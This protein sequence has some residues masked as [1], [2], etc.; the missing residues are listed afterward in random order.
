MKLQGRKLELMHHGDDVAL[1]HAE[2][3]ALDFEIADP[4]DVFGSTTLLAVRRFQ[5]DH[6]L[7]VTGIVDARTA[8]L[9]NQAVDALPRPTWRVQGRLL[10]SDGQAMASARVRAF[11]KRLRR[12][13]VLG[14][15]ATDATGAYGIDYP[16]PTGGDISLY[17]QAFS[18]SGER[19]AGSELACHAKPVETMDLVAGDGV[20]R[21]RPLFARLQATLQ[22]LLTPDRVA[23][24]E[25]SADDVHWL[26]CRHGLDEDQLGRY[27]AAARLAREAEL[28]RE[29][30]ALFGLLMQNL[31]AVLQALLA[32]APRSLRQALERAIAAN[33]ISAALSPRIGTIIE[34][35]Q[36]VIVRLALREPAPERP[37]FAL[38]FDVA[39]TPAQHRE[40]LLTDHLRHAGTLAEFWEAQR[41][42]LGDEATGE[43]QHVLRIAALGL[44]HAPLLRRLMRMRASGEV[45]RG[46]E[47]LARFDRAAWLRLI[48]QRE[49]AAAIGAPSFLG[50]EAEARDNLFATYLARFVEAVA[51]TRVLTERLANDTPPALAA[52]LS[53]L[54]R[55]PRFEFRDTRVGDFLRAN[56]RALEGDPDPAA[57]RATLNAMQRLYDLAPPF[58]K[59]R[60]LR[61]LGQ[62]IDSA[63]QIR[64][65]GE[66]A[67]VRQAS[68]L[69]GGPATARAVYAKAAQKADT[70]VLLLSQSAYMN[71]TPLRA[72]PTQLVGPGMPDLADLFGS[73]DA[74]ECR[75]C[76][77]VYSPAAYLVD[78]LHFLMNCR[79]SSPGRS[80]LA[81][82]FARR[83]DLGEVDLTCDN[84]HTTLPYVDLVVEI[85]ENAVAPGGAFPFQTAGEAADLLASPAHVQSAAYG[86]QDNRL[87]GAV[88]PWS[89]PFD[90]WTEVARS[91]LQHMGVPRVELIQGFRAASDANAAADA[92]AEFLG[93]TA[94][95]RSALLLTTLTARRRFWGFANAAA[96][97]AFVQARNVGALLHRARMTYDELVA[98][99]AVPFVDRASRL[100]VEFAG[101]DCNLDTA[102]IINL[103]APALDRLHRFMR[104]QRKLPW[105]IDELGALLGTLIV[106][107]LDDQ[108]LLRIAGV[109]RLQQALGV[110]LRTLLGWWALRMDTHGI[111]S[112]LSLYDDVFLDPS[113]SQ[114]EA[115]VFRLN[116]ARSE[117]LAANAA[118][119]SASLPQ[120][121]TALGIS[122]A[123][124]D[125]LRADLPNDR[126]NLQNLTRLQASASLAKALRLKVADYLSLRA[127]SGS[128]PTGPAAGPGVTARFVDLAR[129]A[130]LA[131]L[132]LPLLDYL[133]RHRFTA[134]AAFALADDQIAVHLGRLRAALRTSD[135]EFLLAPAGTDPNLP[136]FDAD[137][138]AT[139]TAA[140]LAALLPED[141]VRQALAV[142]ERTSTA[143]PADLAT[144]IQQALGRFLD[145]AE[146][147]E[148][149][150]E[151]GTLTE[152]RERFNYFLG[153]LLIY[154]RRSG[155]EAVAVAHAAEW[156]GI[157]PALA[158]TLLR[159]LV[160][161][162]ADVS[163][164]IVVDLV[165]NH[166]VGAVDGPPLPVLERSA[167]PAP[168]AALERLHKLVQAAKRL[169]LPESVLRF[170]IEEGPSRGWI[171]LAALPLSPAAEASAALG[172]FLSMV[173]ALRA[174]A[175]LPGGWPDFLALLQAQDAAGIGRSGY[176]DAVTLRT[177]WDRPSVEFVSG[178]QGLDLS[179]P[180][181]YRSGAFLSAMQPR[182]AI[183]RRLGVTGGTAQAW[184][185]AAVSMQ[186]AQT[187][188]QTARAKY[189]DKD[190]WLAV[191]R[192]LRDPLRERQRAAL[193]DHLLHRHGL[194]SSNEL[195]GHY[196]VD[197]EMSPCM[198]T[199]RMVLATAS[200]QLFVQRCLLNLE[201]DVPPS[202]IDTGQWDWMKNYR[203]WEANR[204]VFLYPENWIEPE[205]RDDKSPP[206]LALEQGLL[207]DE[208]TS[209]TVEREYLTYLS[210]LDQV[211][212]LEIVAMCVGPFGQQ[213]DAVHVFGRTRNEPHGYFY[214][215]W[216][217][218]SW[219]PWEPMDVGI[220]GNHLVPVFWNGRLTV[221]W[222]VFMEKAL[223]PSAAALDPDAP[224]SPTKY[225]DVSL[226]W[227]ELREESWSAKR[228]SEAAIPSAA[229][230]GSG[231]PTHFLLD[232]ARH[233]SLVSS[234]SQDRSIDIGL[235]VRA[236]D[237][238]IEF[239]VDE[240]FQLS[241]AGGADRATTSMD[242]RKSKLWPKDR[243]FPSTI[244]HGNTILEDGSVGLSVLTTSGATAD[245]AVSLFGRTPGRF[246]V[247][248][249]EGERPFFCRLPFFYL[250]RTRAF[251][252]V[253]DGRYLVDGGGGAHFLDELTAGANPT[254]APAAPLPPRPDLPVRVAA[255]HAAVASTALAASAG[256]L[257][258]IAG[259]AILPGHWETQRFHFQSHHHPFVRLLVEQLSRFGIDGI[260]KPD[261][262]SE[263]ALPGAFGAL[264]RQELARPYFWADYSP[265]RDVVEN[266]A[267][268]PGGLIAVGA[269]RN[270]QP[271]DD[272]DFSFGGAYTIYN[273]ELFFH[274]PF[275]IAKR[276][277]ANRRFSEANRWFTYL[278]DPT[279]AVADQEASP[280]S[281]AERA[282]NTK[283]FVEHGQ[284]RS[285]ERLLLLL[286]QPG[287]D[288]AQRLQRDELNKQLK[289]WRANPFNPHLIARLR[290]QPYMMA[291][292][293]AY[294][295]NLIAWGDD[296]FRRDT[297][298]S[299][300]EASQ[301][302][303]L[304]AEV[305]GHRPRE[306]AAH[307]GTRRIVDGQSVTNFN[308]LRGRLDRFSNALIELETILYPAEADQGAA[309]SGGLFQ[310]NDFLAQTNPDSGHTPDLG[311]ATPIP[312]VV[313]STLFF[314]VPRNEKLVAYWDTVA[315]RLF[316]IRHCMNIEGVVRQLPLFQPPIDPALLVRAAAAGVDV[317]A[318]VAD[319]QTPLP[320]YRFV[321]LLQKA[322]E[323]AASVKAL[324]ASLLSALEKRDAEALSLLRARQESEVLEHIRAVKLTS[325]D[326]A[327]ANIAALEETR[328]IV[329]FRKDFYGSRKRTNA[330]EDLQQTKLKNAFALQTSSQA[331]ELL[332]GSLA[333]IP[334]FNAG[335]CGAFGTPVITAE[336]GGAQFS[337]AV[338]VASRALQ[339][340]ASI[341][342]YEGSKAG[343]D[344]GF[345]RRQEEWT[346]QFD[347][348]ELELGQ[349]DKQ[350]A[351]ARIRVAMGE[352]DL[353]AHDLQIA[354]SHVVAAYLS[355]KY[356]NQE[357][358]AWMAGQISAIHFQSYQMAMDLA[359]RAER[360]FRFE[361]GIDQSSFVSPGSWDSQRKG[362]QAGERLELDLQRLEA[363]Y[364]DQ[365]KR[366]YEITRHISLRQLDPLALLSLR[367]TGECV[368][369]LPEWLFDLDGPGH[370]MRRIK[371]LSLS[372][373][374]VVG[375][376]ASVNC[377]A[378]LL[379][380]SV[381]TSA[382]VAGGYAR[383]G[384]D[385]ARF[386]DHFGAIESVVTSSASNDSGMFEANLRDERYLPFEGGGAIGRW[387]LQLPGDFRQFDYATIADAI[388]HLRYT[389]RDGGMPLRQAAVGNLSAIL[390]QEAGG[391]PPND[392]VSP[393]LLLGL[394]SD[395]P[396]EW[397]RFINGDPL[398]VAI[399][400]DRFP[401]LAQGRPISVRQIQLVTLSDATP[402]PQVLAPQQVGL[403]DFPEFAPGQQAEVALHLA[404]DP[405]LLDRSTQV[406]AFFLLAYTL[407]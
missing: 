43:L 397:Q 256:S 24:A 97:N 87:G 272:F 142:V 260:L 198:L 253:P 57:T 91:Y 33:E 262:R 158:D 387:R 375:P 313:G 322:R 88:Y 45:G 276:L 151:P 167:L 54:R 248:F 392:T 94:A 114:P 15:G 194:Q 341:Q 106:T 99:L 118:L 222:P 352:A 403:T 47:D 55:Q 257:P 31:P 231:T 407:G 338:Q 284:G 182:L 224:Q 346:F 77:S 221:F 279:D 236:G 340:A 74:C 67:F 360:C 356:S 28:P 219:T 204:K 135:R 264:R 69:L 86:P 107:A 331:V 321:T 197:V 314:C 344:A 112:D 282:W 242:S 214:R 244:L 285:I 378:S 185:A 210:S 348:A 18:A 270:L 332:A 226:A 274:A 41:R 228:M 145:P 27:A 206:F 215:R 102:T 246:K 384:E 10:R 140:Q 117:L 120:V 89:L 39:G 130:S 73:L 402:L 395:Y 373:P 119:L 93:L 44:N 334:Q 288:K 267:D 98:V 168:F 37:T 12:D 46:I 233:H 304:A 376:Y 311:F 186:V 377:T 76:A 351:A 66:S 301:L 245:Q 34:A 289:A 62:S 396:G 345:D 81:V 171:D 22:P 170:A 388:L 84:T 328:K 83:P 368:F 193:V 96:L 1:L 92:A 180:Q 239:V 323:M 307:D 336:I 326:E 208:V 191:A 393:V 95:D 14:E 357:L 371:S 343:I 319:L 278:F 280:H 367:A 354:N 159:E 4:P 70:A 9:I 146:A 325:L 136:S 79:S 389:A 40:A 398:S 126:L 292:V 290:V 347:A 8:R 370:F 273:W 342:T 232:P 201:A 200:V 103:D 157:E 100:R 75:H 19:L 195:Y 3:R 243:R 82:L 187:I 29:H 166:F 271:R 310:A 227:S 132:S 255:F 51:P 60:T 298:E 249:P 209:S 11:E 71:R 386:V 269:I 265:N 122:G 254:H 183:L 59:H 250:D 266:V 49:G 391:D 308:H 202:A 179:W 134:N 238:S 163:R 361:L 17:V 36:D 364:L 335:A 129:E 252:V 72:L 297:M 101:A 111:G 125:L 237:D 235:L 150:V 383:S 21:G 225:H 220:E 199:S 277:S 230:F 394:R 291:V 283:P 64:R 133:L 143:A 68:A 349:I 137:P 294:L 165:S 56:P 104:L 216:N 217:R 355:E 240:G 131:G 359:K 318:A 188:V 30:E 365:H 169:G 207:Q 363:A 116:A 287:L 350:I 286:R 65:L 300:N 400:R 175:G 261:P 160:R 315:D 32:Q 299:I 329:V 176:L 127:L 63:T 372:L 303:I 138:D 369:D 381:R 258:N 48:R 296:L 80:A 26:A 302:Y 148:R 172:S 105:R 20:L 189:P 52:G 309:E 139:R 353:A 61:L 205:L 141:S 5:S 306:T 399:G 58:D 362:L 147:I 149:L 16:I 161:S 380:S 212:N 173:A 293:M 358:Y 312:S 405:P 406:Q 196:L 144:F 153:A 203:V 213:K 50:T 25:L 281:M 124:L 108:A 337:A 247:I 330:K 374:C 317:G 320:R 35:L 223:E 327:R 339:L 7:P 123:D 78:I 390:R 295:D 53:F 211:A 241:Q 192:P 155:R 38:L 229:D 184:S 263:P 109:K 305:L 401:Y 121:H 366:D 13:A 259:A 385:A 156:L 152:R 154:R 23:P 218:A 90:L 268:L 333:L 6:H 190:A 178:E 113:A 379:S 42:R 275:L 382:A 110:P 181:G 404:D 251:F 316:K 164:P 177:G 234:M 128:E 324:G 2:L 162:P 115:E 85:L 174:G